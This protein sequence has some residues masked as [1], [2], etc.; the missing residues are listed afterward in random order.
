VAGL[1][2]FEYRLDAPYEQ[3]GLPQKVKYWQIAEDVE[4]NRL[5]AEVN[6]VC[7]TAQKAHGVLFF[8]ALLENPF[9]GIQKDAV[10]KGLKILMQKTNPDK[11]GGFLNQFK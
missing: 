3:T 11:V 6:A 1:I 10:I 5:I 9:D 2:I 4:R 8:G 7:R